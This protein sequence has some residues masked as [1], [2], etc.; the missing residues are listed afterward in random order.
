MTGQTKIL[1]GR[2]KWNPLLRFLLGDVF[3]GFLA[4]VAAALTLIPLLF[5]VSRQTADL[6]EMAQWFIILLFA[7]EYALGL[8]DARSK[9]LFVLNPWRLVDA[10]TIFLPLVS[11][12]PGISGF[13]RSTPVLRLLRLARLAALGARAGGV[14]TH[15]EQAAS[16]P[17]TPAP[18][19]IKVLPGDENAEP[20]P[21][22]WDEFVRWAKDP[23]EQWFSLA[24]VGPDNLA[25]VADATG[26]PRDFISKHLLATGYPHA[27]SAGRY[28]SLFVWLP[29]PT[30]SGATTRNGLLLLASDRSVVTFCQQPTQLMEQAARTQTNDLPNLPFPARMTCRFLQAVLDTNETLVNRF[31]RELA[32]LEDLPVRES[33]PQFFERTF[34]LKKELSAALTDLWRLRGVLKELAE[35]KVRLPGGG[36]ADRS[37]LRELA[38][39]ADYLYETAS[40][41][42]EGVLSLI[43]LHLNVVSFEMN[44][45]MRVL[46]VLSAL[47][48]IP[49]IVGGLLGMNL[50][51]N[52]WPLTLSQVAFSVC[53]AMVT[54]LYFFVVKGWLR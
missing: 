41:L 45:V 20:R 51:D 3:L 11:L 28:F 14:L 48:L 10:A 39:S 38:D 30:A 34:R 54:C 15:A 7:I 46:A 36:P 2:G 35:G 8:A 19:Q 23:G 13:L 24:N 5:N 42:R 47:G 22:T 6:L 31:E 44:R 40:N 1:N 27:E 37:F 16:I 32:D 25:A 43:D 53:L 9:R 29:Q 18:M 17:H 49:S 4:I 52:P 21:A 26:I 50:A 12:I 33:R